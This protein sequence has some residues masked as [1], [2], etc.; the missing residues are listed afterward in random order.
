VGLS[1]SLFQ[2][3]FSNFASLPEDVF[4][5]VKDRGVAVGWL[6]VDSD[7]VAKLFHQ[8]A[9]L[10]CELRRRQHA[11]VIVQIAFAA[12]TQVCKSPALDPKNGAAL[13]AFGNLEFFFAR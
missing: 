1:L 11:D 12:A 13:G 4:D 5:L 2:F 7:R 9:L 8:F 6:V 10:A 3:R